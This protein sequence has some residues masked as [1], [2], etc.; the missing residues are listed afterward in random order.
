MV[1]EKQILDHGIQ[2]PR[3]VLYRYVANAHKSECGQGGFKHSVHR[4]NLS[5]LKRSI[6]NYLTLKH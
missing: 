6:S 1:N 5:F 4:V 3:F 2:S